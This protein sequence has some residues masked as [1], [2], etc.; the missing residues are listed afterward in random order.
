MFRRAARDPT[1]L[2][3][4]STT[5]V[6]EEVL[7]PLSFKP[8]EPMFIYAL[9]DSSSPDRER[10]GAKCQLLCAFLPSQRSHYLP[11]IPTHQV[12]QIEELRYAILEMCLNGQGKALLSTIRSENHRLGSVV[13]SIDLGNSLTNSFATM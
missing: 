13:E 6:R 7:Y 10:H 5:L 4:K 12:R 9:S 8:P 1:H 11:V 3:Y 2:I